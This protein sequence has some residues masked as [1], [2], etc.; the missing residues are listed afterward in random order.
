MQANIQHPRNRFAPSVAS[1]LGMVPGESRVLVVGLGVT[2]FSVVRFLVSRGIQVAIVDSRE[3]PPCLAEL[4]S[5]NANLPVFLGRFDRQAFKVATHLVVSPGI[6][7]DTEEIF[8]ALELGLPLLSDIDLFAS[9]VTSPVVGITGSN[10]KSTVTSL[11]GVMAKK[12][13]W[14]VRVGGNLGVPALDLV[15]EDEPVDLYILELSSFQLERTSLFHCAAATVLNISPDHMDRH[16]DLETYA[17]AKQSIFSNCTV[18]VLNHDDSMVASMAKKDQPALY[19]GLDENELLDFSVHHSGDGEWIVRRGHPLIRVDSVN[20]K[21]KHNISNALASLALGQ[22]IGLSM[23]PML[24]GLKVFQ[25]LPHRMQ[26][27][28]IDNDIAWVNDSKATNVGACI[29]AMEGLTGKVVLIAGGDGKGAD[30]SALKEA[31]KNTARAVVLIG[32][33]A[34]YLY[35]LFVSE[36]TTIKALDLQRAVE[37]SAELARPGDTVLLSPACASLDQFTDYQER[38]RAFEKAVRERLHAH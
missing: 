12:A 26:W 20:I 38:G 25:G 35:S 32:K 30:F 13:G 4:Q 19:F 36:V 10:G 1:A 8:Q 21:G 16:G 7:L 5:F 9:V 33:D 31:V 17:R 18:R 14:N 34:D 22:A 29:A 24:D 2:G 3:N 23:E 37:L 28:A 27:V 6:S 11:L 15:N